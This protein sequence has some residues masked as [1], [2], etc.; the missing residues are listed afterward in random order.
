LITPQEK[1]KQQAILTVA[2]HDFQKGLNA[3]AFFKL[4]DHGLGEGMVQ[5]TFMKTWVYL[6]KGGKIDL[7]KAFLYHVLNN[8]IIDEY[9]RHKTSS[10][11]TLIENGFEPTSDE[12]D[13]VMN[14]LDGKKAIIL[15]QRL[16]EIYRQIMR[17]H[18]VQNLSLAEISQVT[19][20][21][22]NAIAVKL[23]RGLVKLRILYKRI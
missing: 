2:H 21:T 5:E 1:I 18:Y 6:V 11:D 10:L 16:P 20:Q 19:G 15:I 3:R 13:S 23:H 7:M 8:L 4:N 17:L 14:F 12:S 22:K 9:R